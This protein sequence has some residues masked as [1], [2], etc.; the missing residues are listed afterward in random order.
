MDNSR[1]KK[2]GSNESGVYGKAKI[3]ITMHIDDLNHWFGSFP[4]N[5]SQMGK[6]EVSPKN[7]T[8]APPNPHIVSTV[9]IFV[10]GLSTLFTPR[11]K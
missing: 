3:I 8:F 2:Y 11:V 7:P 4:L 6:K 1:M 9:Q 10:G 5:P